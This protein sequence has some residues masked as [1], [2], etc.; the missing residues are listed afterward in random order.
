M[1]KRTGLQRELIIVTYVNA[2]KDKFMICYYMCFLKIHALIK[3]IQ[4]GSNN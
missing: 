2:K 3:K 4:Y 1:Q